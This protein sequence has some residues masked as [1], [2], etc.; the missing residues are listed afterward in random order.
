MSFRDL[1]I[2]EVLNLFEGVASI[3]P[4]FI[5]DN[6]VTRGLH[7][8]D[9]SAKLALGVGKAMELALAIEM[10]EIG[11]VEFVAAVLLC[12]VELAREVFDDTLEHET[13]LHLVAQQLSQ[14]YGVEMGRSVGREGGLID[15]DTNAHDAVFK[16][17]T[18]QVI[19]DEHAANLLVATIDVVGPLDG[20]GHGGQLGHDKVLDG[21]TH[22]KGYSL[23]KQE[24]AL[25]GHVAR[26]DKQTE[27]QVL[28]RR[29]MPM[30]GAGAATC[31]LVFGRNERD[32]TLIK[33]VERPQEVVR[34]RHFVELKHAK[35]G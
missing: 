20:H 32:A 29:R 11:L 12:Q 8:G 25:R 15:V 9:G 13:A 35:P 28:A 19:L 22:G 1:G 18:L 24:H 2:R 10:G 26:V 21:L 6:E 33:W 5:G 31:R 17:L 4:H 30:V 34:A 14:G 3:L 27:Q 23:G 16:L 7:V